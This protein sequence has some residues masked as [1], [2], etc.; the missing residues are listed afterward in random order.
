MN[1]PDNDLKDFGR[2]MPFNVPEGYFDSLSRQ[3][4]ASAEIETV[5][6]ATVPCQRRRFVGVIRRL[7]VAASIAL[8]IAAVFAAVM[9]SP[10]VTFEDVEEVY[11]L[12]SSEDQNL[13]D[14]DYSDDIFLALTE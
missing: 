1:I 12:M 14:T 4:L 2:R 7:A 11:S 8:V 3:I 6:A 5:T 10:S 13:I 9:R